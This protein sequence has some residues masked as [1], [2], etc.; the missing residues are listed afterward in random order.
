[1]VAQKFNNNGIKSKA[2]KTILFIF[3]SL[4]FTICVSAQDGVRSEKKD[5]KVIED[6]TT[7]KVVIKTERTSTKDSSVTKTSVKEN[8]NPNS[9]KSSR[10]KK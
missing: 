4:M 2:M 5:S 8:E 3:S 7:K 9:K 1:L 6:N 10:V